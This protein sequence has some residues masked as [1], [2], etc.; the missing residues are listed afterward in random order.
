MKHV[1]PR[2]DGKWQVIGDNAKRASALTNTQKDAI[3]IAKKICI[4]QREELAIHGENGRIREK[5]TYGPIDSFPPK[6]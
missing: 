1:T 3:K 5:N 4:N 6:G 2:P